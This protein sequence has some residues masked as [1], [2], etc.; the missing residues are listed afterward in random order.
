MLSH[1]RVV[2]NFEFQ[3]ESF[4]S[5]KARVICCS[6]HRLD[7]RVR[8]APT[9]FQ[10]S[11]Q[12]LIIDVLL[13]FEEAIGVANVRRGTSWH[14]YTILRGGSKGYESPI[15]KSSFGALQ[16]LRDLKTTAPIDL[17][18]MSIDCPV[19]ITTL[20]SL[21]ISSSR[22]KE[23]VIMG[24]GGISGLQCVLECDIKGRWPRRNRRGSSA[25]GSE[26]NEVP[27]W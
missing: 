27:Y 21:Y 19:R 3:V 5:S 2:D 9:F 12:A 22:S 8:T 15:D 4:K 6:V 26:G 13:L 1:C 16:Q 17:Y 10:H 11:T 20:S 24:A 7:F 25:D 18:Q 23:A 14:L